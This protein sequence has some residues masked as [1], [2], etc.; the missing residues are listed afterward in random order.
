MRWLL[1]LRPFARFPRTPAPVRRRVTQCVERG[2]GPALVVA[3]P[4]VGKTML[5]EVLAEKFAS[6]LSVVRLDALSICNRRALLQ[7][8]LCEWGQPF[9]RMDDG[10]LQ[11]AVMSYVKRRDVAPRGFL[12]LVDD[13]HAFGAEQILELQGLANVCFAGH[14]RVRLVLAGGSELDELI[15]TPE[16]KAFNQRIAARGYLAPLRPAEVGE[17][18]RAHAAAAGADPD[19]LLDRDALDAVQQATDGV[20]RLVNQLCDHAIMLAIE[21]GAACVTRQVVENAWADLHQLPSPWSASTALS[22]KSQASGNPVATGAIE[23]GALDEEFEVAAPQVE[24]APMFNADEALVAIRTA[25]A[26]VNPF[27]EEF[28]D[29]EV[30]LD[31]YAS[32]EA[33]FRASTPRVTNQRDPQFARTLASFVAE[34]EGPD[35]VV[36]A[37]LHLHSAELDE[38]LVLED[39]FALDLPEEFALDT[40]EIEPDILVLEDDG[41]VAEAPVR[42]QEYRQLFSS[43]R[44]G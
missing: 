25:P 3:A 37:R 13:A 11:L 42:R 18:I 43:L 7:A 28:A 36:S 33:A 38:D 22:A 6:Q 44:R 12:F 10:E 19:A 31:R 35:D 39:D 32:L 27:L 1:P 15:A 41:P 5:L 24:I 29:E 16:L 14:P 2:D 4:G 26:A 23:F 8:L 20:P 17:Y 34:L 9:Q 40:P 21:T 30:V